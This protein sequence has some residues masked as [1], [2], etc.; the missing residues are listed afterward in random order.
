MIR[1]TTI[2][3]NYANKKKLQILDSIIVESKRVI[4]CF[5]HILWQQEN[6]SSKFIDFKVETW[7]SARMLQNLGKQALEVV[8]SQRRKKQKVMPI[9]KADTIEFDSRFINIQFDNNS[10]DIWIKLTSIGHKINLCLPSKKHKHFLKFK[11]WRLKN[12]IKLRRINYNYFIDLYFEKEEPVKKEQGKVI[13][14]DIGYKKL[15]ID[16]ENNKYDDGLEKIYTKISNKKQGSKAFDRAIIER[17]NLIN[18]SI[19]KMNLFNIKEIV[20]EDLR[21]VKHKSK[22]RILKIFNI[23]LQRWSYPKVLN[24]LS[25]RC[26]EEAVLFTKINPAFTSQQ[27]SSCGQIDKKSRKLEIYQCSCGLLIDADYNA[28]INISHMGVYSPHA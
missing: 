23:K 26:E 7:L 18:Q 9:Y 6:F 10:Y 12:S 5:I 20:V 27:C 19:N 21:N 4:K 25:R 16:S 13:G 28:A 1:K 2:N 24:K 15:L 8:K 11:N 3:I 14:C 22:K 17:N